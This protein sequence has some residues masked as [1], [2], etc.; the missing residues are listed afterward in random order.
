M[1]T[2]STSSKTVLTVDVT[3]SLKYVRDLLFIYS[4][5]ADIWTNTK[6]ERT[7]QSC[8]GVSKL[9]SINMFHTEIR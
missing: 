5:C 3:I 8:S 7:C 9:Q 1:F 2:K 4:D 6:D